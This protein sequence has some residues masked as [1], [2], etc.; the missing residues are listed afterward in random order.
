VYV[1]EGLVTSWAIRPW[2]VV[3]GGAS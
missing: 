2:N 1:H 3:V